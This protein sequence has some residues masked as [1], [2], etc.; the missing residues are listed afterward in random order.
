MRKTLV[1]ASLL[2]V[3]AC[4]PDKFP[5]TTE[6]LRLQSAGAATDCR[7]FEAPKAVAFAIDAG[8]FGVGGG[9]AR[10]LVF[11]DDSDLTR[12]T[13][14]LSTGGVLRI[15]TDPKRRMILTFSEGVT[16]GEANRVRDAFLKR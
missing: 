5:A 4:S 1:I 12:A 9:T 16:P 6:C 14:A 15:E 8:Q 13:T 7:G 10:L 11:K 2:T 3:A